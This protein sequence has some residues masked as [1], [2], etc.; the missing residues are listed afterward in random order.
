MHFCYML[1]VPMVHTMLAWPKTPNAAAGNTMRENQL[2]RRSHAK[3]EA[4][5]GGS[6]RLRSGQT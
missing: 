6:P 4:L 2:E 1:G 5:I 3:K